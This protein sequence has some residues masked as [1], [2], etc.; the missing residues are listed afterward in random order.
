MIFQFRSISN[1]NRGATLV[2]ILVLG[3]VIALTATSILFSFRSRQ[4]TLAHDQAREDFMNLST[5]IR[6]LFS[7]KEACK[8]NLTGA[9]FGNTLDQ[10][11]ALS[12]T[13]DIKVVMRP[14][15]SA[16]LQTYIQK[17]RKIDRLIIQ[18]TRFENIR[19][20][21]VYSGTDRTYLA[22][23]TISVTDSFNVALKEFAL[24]FYLT[25]NAGGALTSC[26]ATSYPLES[27][28][29]LTMEDLL[30]QQL[31]SNNTFVFSPSEH[32]CVIVSAGGP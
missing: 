17:N 19:P 8:L 18:G 14:A 10:L 28:P 4:Q 13:R 22:D 2:S 16:A 32:S 26:F 1:N 11:K 5:Q 24:P 31:R 21:T 20:L 27:S 23:F 29:H 15:G 3:A 6:M 12:T 30:C 25:T 9:A 7:S